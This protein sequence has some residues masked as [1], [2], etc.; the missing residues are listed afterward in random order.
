LAKAAATFRFPRGVEEWSAQRTESQLLGF[1]SDERLA[2]QRGRCAA[3]VSNHIVALSPLAFAINPEPG[4][5]AGTLRRV[6]HRYISAK[7]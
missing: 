4:D 5:A 2:S 3:D 7:T 1:S 6:Y